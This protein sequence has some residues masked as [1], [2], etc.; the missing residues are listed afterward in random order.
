MRAVVQRVQSARI[1]VVGPRTPAADPAARGSEATPTQPSEMGAGLLCLVAVGRADG[2]D[3]ARALARKIVH[4]RVFRDED[5]VAEDG[6]MNRSLLD[7]GGTLG[8]VSNFTLYGDTRKGRRPFF[9]NAALPEVAE[10]LL[11]E[12]VA[13]A[14]A[15]GVEVITG[16]F[17]ADMDVELVNTGPVTLWLDTA[18]WS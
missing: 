5:G 9:G 18:E 4:L 13:A 14:K 2:L 3:E 17:G 16:R 10:P 7:V 11:A 6:R 8:I 1:R 12:L 15:E